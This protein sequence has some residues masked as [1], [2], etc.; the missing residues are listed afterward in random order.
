MATIVLVP[1]E[2]TSKRILAARL[3]D[4]LLASGHR[5]VL[6]DGGERS[7][8][9][10]GGVERRIC[11]WRAKPDTT[12]RRLR[13]V[14][15]WRAIATAS[16]SIDVDSVVE[17]L[18]EVGAELVLVDIEE[19]EFVVAMRARCPE[20]PVAVLSSF[21]GLWPVR[22][23]PP[24]DS[25]MVPRVGFRG[26]TSLSVAWW[27]SRGRRVWRDGRYHLSGRKVERASVVRHLARRLGVRR[28]MTSLPWLHPFVPRAVPTIAMIAP[29]L[30]LPQQWPAHVRV[31]GPLLELPDRTALAR[32]ADPD[33]VGFV[34]RAREE[35]APLVVCAFGGFMATDADDFSERIVEVARISPDLRFVAVG[36]TGGPDPE[37]L[38][39]RA[40]LPQRELLAHAAAA[41]VHSGTGTLHECAI[42]GVPMVVYPFAVNDQAGNAARVEYHG[43]GMVGDR[44]RDSTATIASNL[45][46]VLAS[47]EIRRHLDD[48]AM[49][50]RAATQHDRLSPAIDELL[51]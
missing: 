3:A 13:P 43:I 33:L 16:R 2:V 50:L 30:D 46:T 34:G 40:W 6:V 27:I 24:L 5:V 22:G 48:L 10:F 1:G 51:A 36:P 38:L 15:Q 41:I 31:V 23:V 12:R 39:R 4:R 25:P 45:R 44:R 35:G 32:V 37:N 19:H 42:A 18:D 21:F 14:A 47:S 9:R 11:A 20:L 28:E 7:L 49:Q 17:V 29:E 8:D 26:R